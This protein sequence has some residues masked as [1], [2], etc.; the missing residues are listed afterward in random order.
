MREFSNKI[1]FLNQVLG[2]E[3]KWAVAV[4]AIIVLAAVVESFGL[5]MILPILQIIAEGEL[6]GKLASVLNPFLSQFQARLLLP[7]LCL[8]F[9]SLLLLKF[10]LT[11][12]RIFISK[13]FVWQ[14]RLRWLRKVFEKY[15]KAEYAFMLDHKQGD[16]LNNLINET[17][18]GA[19]CLS[20]LLELLARVVL[21]IA[22]Y[23]TLLLVH[24]Q[25]T[26]VLSVTTGI[27][28][29][30]TYQISKK[31]AQEV[32]RKKI[33]LNQQLTSWAAEGIG[34]VRQIK[35]F[36][37]E[38]W[39]RQQFTGI[40]RKL[41]NVTIR[42]ELA[43]MIPTPLGEIVLGFLLVGMI[44][45]FY[46]FT[47]IGL[48]TLLPTLGMFV[49]IGQ[50]LV[51]NISNLAGMRL[52]IHSLFPSVSLAHDFSE[53]AIAQEDLW[54][55]HG[56]KEL[57]QDIILQE[58]EYTYRRGE[59]VL[60]ELNITIPRG[61]TV[62]LTGP[63]GSGKSTIADLLLGLYRPQSGRILIN[64]R[65]MSEWSLS[66]WRNKVGY[67][68]Q[69]PYLF[70]MSIRDNIALGYPDN[71]VTEESIINAAKKAYA[72]D[73]I[74]NLPQ[75]YSTVV[76]DR[77]MKLSGGQRQ[78]IAIARAIIREP[79]FFIFDEATSAL[80]VQSEKMIQKAIE[81]IGKEK[82]LLIIAH[83]NSTIE[84]ADI[85]IELGKNDAL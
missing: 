84:S 53:Q 10:G 1:R 16:L 26:L 20:Q 8:L 69:E 77:G 38:S 2:R 85:V 71:D 14:I 27:L 3:K 79:D 35:T 57:E 74:I 43:R 59:H 61:K 18:R 48:K 64:C 68:S 52:Q 55:G 80:D 25:T 46:F 56:F 81:E 62:A 6:K 44:L 63:S 73:F 82:T 19:I 36:G 47:E 66:T 33:K 23:V 15:L 76:G 72:H 17:Q 75:G 83:R 32:G 70:N 37:L 54:T 45:Y 51:G 65:E 31:F 34:A 49:V 50:R 5:S 24:W 7:V 30:L 29:L 78:R 21:L 67:V 60:S 13:R 42:F 9:L 28:F 22:L 11:I 39:F 40:A 4:C 12:V 58:V 41:Y